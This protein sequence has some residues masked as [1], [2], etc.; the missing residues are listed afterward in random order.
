MRRSLALLTRRIM[1]GAELKYADIG[2]NMTDLQFQGIYH[3]H[4]KHDPDVD[5]VL[6]RARA[7]G[8]SKMLVT[9][10]NL[11]ESQTAINLCKSNPGLLYS[12][13]G[14]H[15]CH[16]TEFESSN[17]GAEKYLTQLRALAID[18]C[19]DK[20]PVRAF[21][22]IGLDYDRLNFA[23]ADVQRKYFEKQLQIATEVNLPLFLHSRAAH[24][25]FVDMLSPLVKEGKLPRGGV[26]HSFTGTV[27]EMKELV[28]LGFSIGINGCS[29][30]TQENLD[31]VKEIPLDKLML[32]T[33][34]P[35][36]EIRPSHASHQQYLKGLPQEQLLPFPAVKKEKFQPGAMVRGRCEP[37]AI[38]LVARV[39]A[40]VKGI[41]VEEVANA[42]WQNSTKMF[43][44]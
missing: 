22:E 18:N 40:G 6:E 20:G 2:A 14:V 9:G 29:L 11:E 32:E 44:N 10:S 28:E 38:V 36:C 33:D 39:V 37:C 17:I 16:A 23:P 41:S 34:G 21:G 12:T 1:T 13:V 30:K 5:Q 8:V 3:S 19:G 24:K 15:P 25:D 26:V 27:E 42:A 31:V 35:W 4:R 7:T 43:F